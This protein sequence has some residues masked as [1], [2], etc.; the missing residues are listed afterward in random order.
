MTIVLIY[1]NNIIVTIS[2]MNYI[3]QTRNVLLSK[4]KI[5]DLEKLKYFLGIELTYSP[6]GQFY[7]QENML[8]SF[9]RRQIGWEQH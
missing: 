7:P 9:C 2:R 8:F 1:I 6:R 5:K 4:F 3:N